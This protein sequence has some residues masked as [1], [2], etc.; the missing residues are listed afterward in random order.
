[1]DMTKLTDSTFRFDKVKLISGETPGGYNNQ[2]SFV[3]DYLYITSQGKDEEQTDIF[4]FDP[5]YRITWKVTQTEEPE[6]SPTL[7]PD[8]KHFSVIRVDKDGETQQIW[9]YRLDQIGEGEAL[10]PDEKKVGYHLWIDDYQVVFFEVGEPHLLKLGNLQTGKSKE[11]IPDIGRS[12]Q[13]IEKG[14]FAFVRIISGKKHIQTY[15][16]NTGE[17]K[18]VIA[19]VGKA[20][21]FE[22]RKNGTYLAAS[23][24]NLYK[25]N[26][27]IDQDWVLIADF[28]EIGLNHISRLA[29]NHNGQLALVNE[30]K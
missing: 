19:L 11:L 4:A 22:L 30:T 6:Y 5:S 24:P 20:Q 23:G 9:K 10:L 17:V 28:S 1:M 27:K 7:M 16:L 26:P 12:F 2:P 25:F 8:G 3:F 13:L 18:E 21:D 14:V 29:L 15:N